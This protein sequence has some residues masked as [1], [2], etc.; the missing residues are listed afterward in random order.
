MLGVAKRPCAVLLICL[1]WAVASLADR[2][3]LKDGRVL[4]G[5]VIEN[6]KDRVAIRI[7]RNSLSVIMDW[8]KSEVREVVT[9]DSPVVGDRLPTTQEVDQYKAEE[10]GKAAFAE[11][12]EA[13]TKVAEENRRAMAE[14][15]KR[16]DAEH[17]AQLAAAPIPPLAPIRIRPAPL[18]RLPRLPRLAPLS[19]LPPMAPRMPA[20][21]LPD[22]HTGSG[23]WITSNIDSGSVIIME[24][25]AIWKIDPFDK[26]D[27][28]TWSELDDVVIVESDDGSAGYDFL[29][30]NTDEKEKAHAKLVGEE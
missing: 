26:V 18:V 6:S 5:K 30:I 1:A 11:E 9:Y 19:P 24:D 17:A 20:A 2:V 15:K 7:G 14:A 10:A 13:Q 29:I 12:Q 22:D 16:Y 25:G 21:L 23:H 4:E 3:E 8:P 27:A 28:M